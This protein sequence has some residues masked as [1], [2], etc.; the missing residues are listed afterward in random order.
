[1]GVHSTEQD[2]NDVVLVAAYGDGVEVGDRADRY[3]TYII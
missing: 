2:V 1:M 3:C